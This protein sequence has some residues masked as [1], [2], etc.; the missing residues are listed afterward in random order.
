[1]TAP[2]R[3]QAAE[4]TSLATRRIPEFPRNHAGAV[5]IRVFVGADIPQI[6][7][8]AKAING[9]PAHAAESSSAR[10]GALSIRRRRCSE[11]GRQTT[12]AV[13]AKLSCP[14]DRGSAARRQCTRQPIRAK[15]MRSPVRIDR[16]PRRRRDERS[17]DCAR[18]HDRWENV[19][20]ALAE[21]RQ[22]L[23]IS[24]VLLFP[25]MRHISPP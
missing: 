17:A 12:F 24:C 4:E 25:P 2:P 18:Q 22:C 20:Q 14:A 15:W 8:P 21:A 13:A 16:Q 7:M 3:L 23:S 11:G 9:L 1:L 19:G 10:I 6:N 5:P